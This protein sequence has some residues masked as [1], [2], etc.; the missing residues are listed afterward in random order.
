MSKGDDPPWGALILVALYL[1]GLFLFFKFVAIWIFGIAVAIGVGGVVYLYC[2]SLYRVFLGD[3]GW[4]DV[5]V[6]PEPAFRQYFFNKAWE[7][8]RLVVVQ[9]YLPSR[10]CAAFCHE[11]IVSKFFGG[12][13]AVVS[14]PPGVALYAGLVASVIAAAVFYAILGAI[15][16]A[17]LSLAV[18]GTLV[19]AGLCRLTA[20]AAM[21]WHHAFHACPHSDCHERFDLAYHFCGS[22]GA[23]HRWLVPGPYG[24]F[25][26]RCQCGNKLPTFFLT[27]RHHLASA[28]PCCHKM[29]DAS[30]P[31]VGRLDVPLIGG[32]A[33]GKTSFL[34]A[35]T[36][37]LRALTEDGGLQLAFTNDRAEQRF[38]QA[39]VLM[40]L[41]HRLPKTVDLSPD[42]FQAVLTNPKGARLL[43]S[44]FDP[45]GEIYTKSRGDRAQGYFAY[46]GGAVMLIDPFSID[47]VRQRFAKRLAQLSIEQV[48]F[49]AEP[50]EDVYARAIWSANTMDEKSRTKPMAVVVTK[51]DLFSLQTEILSTVPS[52]TLSKG[53]GATVVDP[54]ESVRAW[55]LEQDEGNLVRL[56][57]DRFHPV[58]FFCTHQAASSSS[59]DTGVLV[60]V[61]WLL[62][63]AKKFHLG[64]SGMRE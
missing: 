31:I 54:S 26:R 35:A 1:G 61:R 8:Y 63:Q 18:G 6:P 59:T 46:Y 15:H 42:A 12:S 36:S 62:Q 55:L 21:K 58:R 16:L 53:D 13:A 56:L 28:C 45:A 7:D 5:P 24:I 17:L 33:A 29:L 25:H 20:Y 64:S 40:E 49:C 52:V 48:T 39:R 38:K 3:G 51:T 41:D 27:G 60:P 57:E 50:P 34:F 10:Q 19:L 47:R 9:A 22:C 2:R 44:W 23:E 43:L 32:P 37:A 30:L 11:N 14:W 4:P